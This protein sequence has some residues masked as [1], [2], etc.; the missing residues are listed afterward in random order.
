MPQYHSWVLCLGYATQDCCKVANIASFLRFGAHQVRGML[1]G[2]SPRHRT[3][4]TQH[5]HL[6]LPQFPICKMRVIVFLY[7]VWLLWL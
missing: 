6:S 1:T 7:T 4:G 2:S 3:D 5:F